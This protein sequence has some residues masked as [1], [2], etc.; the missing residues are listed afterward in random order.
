VVTESRVLTSFGAERSEGPAL[1]CIPAT[2]GG[3]ATFAPWV[4]PLRNRATVWAARLPG[5]ESLIR[6]KPLETIEQMAEI[7]ARAVER[8]PASELTLFGHCSGALIAY[9]LA[10]QL[11]AG[12]DE[13]LKRL[14]VS[15]RRAPES[16]DAS[17]PLENELTRAEIVDFFI[18][19]GGTEQEILE[20]PEYISLTAPTL[21]ADAAAALRY[22]P[23]ASR[24]KHRIPTV[25][26]GGIDD[27]H[28]REA[29]LM[30][31][32]ACTSGSFSY[33]QFPGD[34][35]FLIT[36]REAVVEFLAGLMR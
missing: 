7:M 30:A 3:A 8:L 15:S 9:E 31:W 32:K 23:P 22:R 25:A 28:V 4:G 19:M 14:V 12:T 26:I 29:D 27:D 35:F 1:I 36:Q 24:G 20:S 18:R 10:H 34:H 11:T 21:L 6:E 16:D 5:R 33:R 2:G 17:Q 13:R